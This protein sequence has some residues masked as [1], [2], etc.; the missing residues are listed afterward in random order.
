VSGLT[1][2]QAARQIG[3]SV[4]QVDNALQRAKKKIARGI[5]DLL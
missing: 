3:C 1:Y 5:A 2:R 4:K